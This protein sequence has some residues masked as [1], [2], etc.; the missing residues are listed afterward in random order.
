VRVDEVPQGI[1]LENLFQKK[2]KKPKPKVPA[3]KELL[4]AYRGK[5]KEL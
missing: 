5:A 3:K 2:A 4:R 1:P